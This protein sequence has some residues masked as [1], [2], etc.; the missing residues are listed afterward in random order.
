MTFPHGE[1]VQRLAYTA[2]TTNAHG[3][4]VPSHAA[5]VDVVGAG[6]APGGALDTTDLGIA[7]SP[8]LYLD[9]DQPA[10]QH[11]LWVVRGELYRVDGLIARWRH[12]HSGWEAGT[13]IQLKRVTG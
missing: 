13:V 5:P 1:T 8:T 2:M 9:Y 12:P 3:V 10:S 11:D 7:S 4:E 6:F